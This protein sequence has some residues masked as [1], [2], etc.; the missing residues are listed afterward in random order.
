MMN[1]KY[2]RPTDVHLSLSRFETPVSNGEVCMPGNSLA[3]A[4]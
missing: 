4:I 2:C 1:R 3:G